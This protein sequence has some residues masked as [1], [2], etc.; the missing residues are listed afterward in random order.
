M[1]HSGVLIFQ[2]LIKNTQCGYGTRDQQK[3]RLN[4]YPVLLYTT[5]KLKNAINVSQKSLT[6]VLLI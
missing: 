2:E 3:V 5:Q 1:H 4:T 6:V